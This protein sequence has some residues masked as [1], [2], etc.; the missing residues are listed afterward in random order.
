MRDKSEGSWRWAHER[1][2]FRFYLPE[3]G[4]LKVQIDFGLTDDSFRPTGPVTVTLALNGHVFD[5]IHCQTAGSQKYSQP[6]PPG[7]LRPNSINVVEVTPDKTVRRP[8][9]GE[10]LAFIL[11]SVGFTE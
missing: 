6:V 9:S 5:R 4:R 7:L 8:E 1:P 11:N 3:A 10:Q 2:V